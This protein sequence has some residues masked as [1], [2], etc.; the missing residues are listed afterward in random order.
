MNKK[1]FLGSLKQSLEGE[2]SSETIEQNL[3]FY[4]QYISSQSY[5]K[6]EKV[7]NDLGSPRLIAKTII[8][9]EKAVK[10]KDEFNSNGSYNSN[11]GNEDE[12][13]RMN[14]RTGNGKTIFFK[15]LNWRLKLTLAVLF[16]L[17]I[18]ILIVI[19]KIIITVLFTFGIP[20]I[21]LFLLFAIFRKH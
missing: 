1:E 14:N 11:F 15:K 20:I 6:E 13:Q 4:D 5:G 8:E 7:I 21:L 17:F 16:I 2:V 3:K 10:N 12:S 9:K 19:G 18:V